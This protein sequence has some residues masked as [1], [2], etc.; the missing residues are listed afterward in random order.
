MNKLRNL[1]I[2]QAIDDSAFAASAPQFVWNEVSSSVVG[3]VQ[4]KRKTEL[5]KQYLQHCQ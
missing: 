4:E 1:C 5:F 2:Q 3:R